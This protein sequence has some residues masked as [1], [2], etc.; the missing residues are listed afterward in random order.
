MLRVTVDSP[1]HY[2]VVVPDI[3]QQAKLLT[4]V[5]AFLAYDQTLPADKQSVF[6]GHLAD[7]QQQC[8]PHRDQFYQSETQRT[9]AS[10]NIKRLE[11][12]LYQHLKQA[13]QNL[14]AA[15]LKML[16]KAEEWGFEVKQTTGNLLFPRRKE[17]RLRVLNTY[18][19]KEESRATDECF[20]TPDL[21][22]LIAI[23]EQLQA[24]IKQYQVNRKQRKSSRVARDTGFRRLR[25]T[26]LLAA[27][28]IT[29]LQFDHIISLD[30]QK[31]GFEVVERPRKVDKPEEKSTQDSEHDN[32]SVD[33]NVSVNGMVKLNGTTK[34]V[35]AS[36]ANGNKV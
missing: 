21:A 22:R 16:E 4:L 24:N 32:V 2:Q 34:T 23:Q 15:F 25:E 10:E 35:L 13:H 36:G 30:L 3:S 5:E 17:D 14:K 19:A 26:L 18:I 12:E 7:L 20:K 1:S 9:I 29:V 31:W 33:N 6:A 27:S 11:E 28:T 8:S